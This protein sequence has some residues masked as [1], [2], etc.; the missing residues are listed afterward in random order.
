MDILDKLYVVLQRED[1]AALLFFLLGSLG[2]GVL[3]FG[4]YRGCVEMVKFAFSTS[5]PVCAKRALS[6]AAFDFENPLFVQALGQAVTPTIQLI[7]TGPSSQLPE[8]PQDWT[9]STGQSLQDLTLTLRVKV[10]ESLNSMQAKMVEELAYM[11]DK[12]DKFQ[13]ALHEDMEKFRNSQKLH[14][15]MAK[16]QNLLQEKVKD[17]LNSTHAHFGAKQ[18]Q[19]LTHLQELLKATPNL[20]LSHGSAMASQAS[21]LEEL[22]KQ[23]Q[24]LQESTVEFKNACLLNEKGLLNLV[25]NLQM[26]LAAHD[27]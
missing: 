25:Q 10:E 5:Q 18:D 12:M 26:E 9:T 16:S 4:F 21:S 3:A 8:I 13:T 17:I 24:A 1:A 7:L 20:T 14:E 22:S 15:D 23:L 19:A 11:Q 6:K 2:F 27:V